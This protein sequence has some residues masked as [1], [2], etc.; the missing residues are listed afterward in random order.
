MSYVVFSVE[1]GD[2]LPC[3]PPPKAGNQPELKPILLSFVNCPKMGHR[4]AQGELASDEPCAFEA[5]EH[6]RALAIGKHVD[7][8]EKFMV[9]PLQRAA[10]R[11]TLPGKIDAATSLL[12]AGL[13]TISERLPQHM[14]D[15]QHKAMLQI[16][17]QAKAAKLGVWAP[18]AA[19]R[20]RQ[21]KPPPTP[22]E[23]EALYRTLAKK[24]EKVRVDRV[25]SGS[26]MF[27]ARL[28]DHQQL[29]IQMTGIMSPPVRRKDGSGTDPLGTEAKFHTERLLLHRHV[30]V[31]FEGVDPH[32]NFLASIVS[33]KGV[34]QAELLAHGPRP[35]PHGIPTRLRTASGT[36]RGREGGAAGWARCVQG[37]WRRRSASVAGGAGAK[38][39]DAAKEGPRKDYDGERDF[40]G[41]FVQ[42]CN[43]DTVVVRTDSGLCIR[44]ALAGV[45]AN[46]IIKRDGGEG[47]QGG[48]RPPEVR[49][50]Y[51]TY[52]WEAREFLRKYVGSSVAVHVEFGRH[53]D[54]SNDVRPCATVTDLGTSKNIG[55]E[56]V[57]AGLARFFL[58]RNETCSCDTALMEAETQAVAAKLGLHSGKDSAITKIVELNRLGEAKGKSYLQFLQRGMQGNRA[59]CSR[60]W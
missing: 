5:F 15:A 18:N 16:Q 35:H 59:P 50:S 26:S 38:P 19:Q 8:E 6:M 12:Q 25:L 20:V 52:T 24:Q 33:P 4:N 9:E 40:R 44:L 30:T 13:A 11:L 49:T 37:G 23:A 34:F 48:N 60:A 31:L 14:E 21:V 55:L 43:G 54:D 47:N 2:R 29:Q 42:A 1:A 51:E 46:K 17:Q 53:F 27:V 57:R 39:A 56:L 3:L 36:A 28:A 45:R 22:E 41:T 7:F 58:G 10:G 32:G